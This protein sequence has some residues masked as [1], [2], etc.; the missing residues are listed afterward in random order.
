MSLYNIRL[1]FGDRKRYVFS[2]PFEV[3]SNELFEL[4]CEILCVDH[5]DAYKFRIKYICRLKIKHVPTV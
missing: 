1:K 5:M 3:I 4:V 2:V